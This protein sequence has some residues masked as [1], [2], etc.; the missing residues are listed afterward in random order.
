MIMSNMISTCVGLHNEDGYLCQAHCPRKLYHDN[1]R[2][3]WMTERN[4]VSILSIHW[5]N[6][7]I[8][9]CILRS[10]V[11]EQLIDSVRI[12]HAWNLTRTLH[13]YIIRSLQ[14]FGNKG[15][16]WKVN[17][18]GE[19]PPWRTKRR[20]TDWRDVAHGQIEYHAGVLSFNTY[21]AIYLKDA[22]RPYLRRYA[23]LICTVTPDTA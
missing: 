7:V 11:D 6:T 21:L 22:L 1:A 13:G 10:K 12:K 8:I 23:G 18:W 15:I 17:V 14:S 2:D 9:P 19:Q 20:N 5:C 4:Q 3:V 16:E